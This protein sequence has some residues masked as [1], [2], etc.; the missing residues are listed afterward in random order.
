[1]SA[2]LDSGFLVL[3]CQRARRETVHCCPSTTGF[4]MLF[5]Y[6]ARG[7]VPV[8][9]PVVLRGLLHRLLTLPV[10]AEFVTNFSVPPLRVIAAFETTAAEF[11]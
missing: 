1:M 3:P 11:P 6:A 2:D 8:L 5:Q 4:I 7:L 9:S 10:F